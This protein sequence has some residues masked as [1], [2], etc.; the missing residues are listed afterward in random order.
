MY[1]AIF[2]DFVIRFFN[3]SDSLVFLLFIIFHLYSRLEHKLFNPSINTHHNT[4][5]FVIEF[6]LQ[7]PSCT[8]HIYRL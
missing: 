2:C 1:Q 4:C 8:Q 7:L 5:I 3:C 6:Y